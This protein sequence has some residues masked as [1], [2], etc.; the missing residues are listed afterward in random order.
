MEVN[1]KEKEIYPAEKQMEERQ[2]RIDTLQT[3]TNR[4][5]NRLKRRASEDQQSNHNVVFKKIIVQ[6]N[7][8]KSVQEIMVEKTDQP[9][10]LSKE[11]EQSRNCNLLPVIREINTCIVIDDDESQHDLM[12]EARRI[13]DNMEFNMYPEIKYSIRDG[14][15]DYDHKSTPKMRS[16]LINWMSEVHLDFKF[17]PLT[18][19]RSVAFVD[20]YLQEDKNIDHETLQLVG[21]AAMYLAMSN[22]ANA[23]EESKRIDVSEFVNICDNSFSATEIFSMLSAALVRAET[24]KLQA[25]RKKFASL[26]F[27]KIS[28]NC[29]LKGALVQ[30]L[31]SQAK[32]LKI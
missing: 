11:K 17:L 30:R 12:V 22:G 28:F 19:H 27:S 8:S 6:S 15:L 32:I 1:M 18:F 21:T 14:F 29:K 3:N 16:T 9:A 5:S 26:Q 4:E 13:R 20:R 24:S 23:N 7:P 31:A 2:S 25:I 10:I